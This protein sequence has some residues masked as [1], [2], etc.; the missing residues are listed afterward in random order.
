MKT[1]VALLLLLVLG[2]CR[3]ERGGTVLAKVGD[4]VLTREDVLAAV[5]TTRAPADQ[6]I[7]AY[8]ISWV[9]NELLHQEASRR[10]IEKSDAFERQLDDVKRQ[11][12]VQ[13]LLDEEDRAD[14][15]AAD[16]ASL[17]A[18][19]DAHAQEFF[20]REDMI[21]LN[22]IVLAR[23]EEAS[24]FAASVSEGAAWAAAAERLAA[25]SAAGQTIRFSAAGAYYSRRT[26]APPDLWKVAATLGVNEVSFP[27]RIGDG[28]A[29]LQL[30]ARLGEGKAAE[31]DFVRDEV[32]ERVM[33]E[34]RRARYDAL[35]AKLRSSTP[36]QVMLSPASSTDTT[37]ILPHE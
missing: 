18:Y 11:L 5:D 19:F 33:M 13:G 24:A 31:F 15:A 9:N 2:G 4:A 22:I 7:R 37:Q 34:R 23:R 10:G 3:Q 35:L 28:F 21:R 6:Q 25:D 30:L 8:V 26:L 29:V 36:I 27:V 32:A 14:T 12:A 1:S 16:S 20:L 17:S